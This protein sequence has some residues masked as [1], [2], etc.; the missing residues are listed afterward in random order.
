MV[1]LVIS[2]ASFKAETKFCCL[3]FIVNKP[4]N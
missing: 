3:S 4:F 1:Y 2:R